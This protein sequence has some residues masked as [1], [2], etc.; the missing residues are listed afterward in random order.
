MAATSQQRSSGSSR[1]GRTGLAWR[2]PAD[3][4]G[5]SYRVRATAA[6]RR[7]DLTICTSDTGAKADLVVEARIAMVVAGRVLDSAGMVPAERDLEIAIEPREGSSGIRLRSRTDREGRFRF[8]GLPQGRWRILGLMGLTE[9]EWHSGA[10]DAPDLHVE[11]PT[12]R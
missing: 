3:P 6:R 4:A 11:H 8:A 7:A 10:G 2:P 9:T 5:S 1:R 12:I